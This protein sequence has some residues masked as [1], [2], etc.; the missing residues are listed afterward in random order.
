MWIAA[1]VASQRV[2]V[3]HV[4]DAETAAYVKQNVW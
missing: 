3:M 4:G 1:F 2:V